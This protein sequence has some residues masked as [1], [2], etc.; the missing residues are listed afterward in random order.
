MPIYRI[1]QKISPL[2][3]QYWVLK[4]TEGRE[5]IGF[6]HQKRFAFKEKFELFTG[7]DKSAVAATIQ[8]RQV[9]DFGAR[10]DI[11]D[12]AGQRLGV[13]GKDFSKSL[14]RSTWQIFSP[15]ESAVIA[16]VRERSLP[17]AIIRRI[18]TAVPVIGD[19]PFP[20]KY[21]F[22][23]I[24]PDGRVA[25]N[26]QKTSLIMDYYQI[27]I[28]DQLAATTDWRVFIGLGIMLDALQSR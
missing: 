4:G 2:A 13:I 17:V 8:A 6:V 9:L 27:D 5:V 11:A 28:D 16:T 3:N 19:I 14:L 23:F 15:D 12:P 7:E 20:V 25:G 18:W 1:Q 26:Y 21:H 22:E 24:T 10:Y